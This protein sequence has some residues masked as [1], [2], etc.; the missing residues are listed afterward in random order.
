MLYGIS[1][2]LTRGRR[3]RVTAAQRAAR[4]NRID[5]TSEFQYPPR[6]FKSISRAEAKLRARRC[7][8]CGER[9]NRR[10]GGW[11]VYVI[12]YVFMKLLKKVTEGVGCL[13][14]KSPK[15]SGRHAHCADAILE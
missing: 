4:R 13:K 7:R 8:G 9:R 2:Y 11:D 1:W 15:K 6:L 3:D 5:F 10:D 12:F 14:K